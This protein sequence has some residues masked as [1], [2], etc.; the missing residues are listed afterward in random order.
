MKVLLINGSPRHKGNTQRA[1]EEVAAA[2]QADDIEAEIAWIGNKPIR[3]CTACGWCGKTGENRCTFDD[4]RCNELIQKAGE[5]DGLIVGSPVYFAGANGSVI[6]LLDRMFY[7]G[8]ALMR[9]KPAAGVGIARRGGTIE[10]VDQIQKYF[11]IYGMPVVSSAYWNIAY[12]R[13]PKEVECDGEGMHTM[14]QLG[15]NMAWLLK[16][17]EAGRE[18]GVEHTIEDKVSTNFIR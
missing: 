2:L 14:R 15:H 13:D 18:A 5:A 1:L 17:I 11:Q 10:T 7:A 16:C 9:Y 4:D 6:S 12:G 3:G 8:G